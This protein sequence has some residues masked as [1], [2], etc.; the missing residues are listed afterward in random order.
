M[1]NIGNRMMHNICPEFQNAAFP[2]PADMTQMR[3]GFDRWHERIL[4]SDNSEIFGELKS[5]TDQHGQN[6][7]LE[8]I[9]GCSPFLTQICLNHPI[10]VVTLLRNG[11]EESFK[12]ALK[13][14]SDY[15][16]T[17]NDRDNTTISRILRQAKQYMAL[18]IAAGDLSG[19]WPLSTTTGYIS[20]CEAKGWGLLDGSMI[21]DGQTPPSGYLLVMEPRK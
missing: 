15:M 5:L 4:E 20:F 13:L 12:S 14:I 7:L 1:H 9:F 6:S 8:A 16:E 19:N 17:E 18:S 2:A 3:L 21:S 10:F 11:P